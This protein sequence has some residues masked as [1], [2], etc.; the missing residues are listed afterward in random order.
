MEF[1]NCEYTVDK[2]REGSLK[3]LSI[4]LIALYCVFTGG[5]FGI[6]FAIGIVPLGAAVPVLLWILV[7]L[8]WRYVK[9]SYSYSVEAGAFKLT[10]IIGEKKRVPVT[11]LRLK[12]CTLIAPAVGNENA[13]AE[14]APVYVYDAAPSLDAED[15][16]IILATDKNGEKVACKCQVTQ[17]TL[18]AFKHY[19]SDTV[20]SKTAR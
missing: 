1:F 14:F 4:L 6:I 11:E 10:K 8:T 7:L 15:I 2:K 9:I 13:L 17:E 18:K 16:Y 3:K 20:M 5:C 19:K 12:E